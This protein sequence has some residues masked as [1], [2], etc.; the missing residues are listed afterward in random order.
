MVTSR[1][2]KETRNWNNTKLMMIFFFFLLQCFLTQTQRLPKTQKCPP[3][4]DMESSELVFSCLQSFPASGSF[5]VSQFFT[6]GGQSIG[7]SASATVLPMN[8]HSWFPLGLTGLI[9]LPS[10]GLSRVFSSTIWKHQ[11]FNAQPSLWYTGCLKKKK[12]DIYYHSSGSYKFKAK[13]SAVDS[14]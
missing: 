14:F 10:K 2:G 7:A 11:L 5:S 13:V 12:K 9:S 3:D 6:S 8:I 4:V 1:L